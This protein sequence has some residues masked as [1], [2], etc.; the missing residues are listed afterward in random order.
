MKD[1]ALKKEE[2]EPEDKIQELCPNKGSKSR[3]FKNNQK[4]SSKGKKNQLKI[5]EIN[6]AI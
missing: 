1:R 6:K 4:K 3:K 2:D 5:N